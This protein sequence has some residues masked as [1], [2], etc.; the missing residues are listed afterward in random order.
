VVLLKF[1][2]ESTTKGQSGTEDGC[3]ETVATI[4]LCLELD[5][6]FEATVCP[7]YDNNLVAKQINLPLHVRV[8]AYPTIQLLSI[9]HFFT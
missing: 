7:L 1:L 9:I 8:K 4:D 5:R 3:N 6:S 2:N